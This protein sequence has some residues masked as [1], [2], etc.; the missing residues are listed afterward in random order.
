MNSKIENIL[1]VNFYK[2]KVLIFKK[3]EYS[4]CL[5]LRIIKTA[6]KKGENLHLIILFSFTYR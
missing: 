4:F 1:K 6:E 5:P 3:N 2:S